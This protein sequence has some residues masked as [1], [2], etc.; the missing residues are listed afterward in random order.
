[1]LKQSR[2]PTIPIC[3]RNTGDY[4]TETKRHLKHH[5]NQKHC[6]KLCTILRHKNTFP[7]QR[8]RPSTSG[9]F[10]LL[11]MRSSFQLLLLPPAAAVVPRRR[12]LRPRLLPGRALRGKN[13]IGIQ[14]VGKLS[15]GEI[16]VRAGK[17]EI[18]KKLGRDLQIVENE[19]ESLNVILCQGR[20]FL[21]KNT[22]VIKAY[23]YVKL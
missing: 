1:M 21:I 2:H 3:A 18:G 14:T 4:D 9:F 15:I 5:S 22:W 16:K 8:R 12:P 7:G 20:S 11:L 13:K 17:N 10:L 23:K 6:G 19:G